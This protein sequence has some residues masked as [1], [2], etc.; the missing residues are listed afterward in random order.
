MPTI[1]SAEALGSAALERVAVRARATTRADRA[2]LLL[3]HEQGLLLAAGDAGLEE[4][5]TCV[6]EAGRA[7]VIRR[8]GVAAGVPLE[9]GGVL[10]GA[11][12]VG[13]H[14]ESAVSEAELEILGDLALMAADLI[15]H[16]ERRSRLA[17][18]VEAGVEAL[19]GLLD[20]RDGSLARGGGEVVSLAHRVADRLAEADPDAAGEVREM[21][22]ERGVGE[23]SAGRFT[24]R[25]TEATTEPPRQAL[26]A[27]FERIE[28]LPA[29]AEP[30]DRLLGLLR[31][32]RPPLG[33]V[34]A[35]IESDVALVLSVLRAANLIA[36]RPSRGVASVREAY[37]T[38]APQGLEVLIER[39]PAVD[40]F[41]QRPASRTPTERFRL[42]AVA[43]QV[44]AE[45]LAQELGH[46]DADELAVAALLHDIGKLVLVDA[47]PGYPGRVLGTAATAEERLRAERRELGID[48]ALVGGVLVRRLGLPS[49]LAAA[50]ERHHAPDADG[51]AAVVRLAD[52]LAHYGHG[53]PVDPGALLQA[54]RRVGLNPR[55]LRTVMY[56][57]PGGLAARRRT[58]EPSPLTPK[59]LSAVRGLAEGKLYKEI[60]LS[61]GVTTSTVR[62]HLHAAYRKMG[63]ADRA[64]AVLIA[65]ERGWL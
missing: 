46:E 14:D 1:P 43:V 5:A 37:A 13:S 53:R 8:K 56:E 32:D 26:S 30:R 38:M 50:I 25:T 2:A 45:R 24:R 44:A 41:E 36:P 22:R 57:L 18:A 29:L 7:V 51:M 28:R 52:L 20:L 27:A 65:T 60:A 62:S 6:L 12:C 23:P 35:T 16:A 21:L 40:F 15:E 39:I 17:G 49:R 54:A 11:L 64:Q 47:Y 19:A 3:F 4:A 63:A 9:V 59:E 48:H 31:L 58:A 34:V 61:L 33:D 10:R 55:A 42:H